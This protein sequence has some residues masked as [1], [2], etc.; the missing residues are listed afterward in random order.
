MEAEFPTLR[1]GSPERRCRL[2]LTWDGGLEAHLLY[3]WDLPTL[4]RGVFQH[5][6][7]DGV[8]GRILFESNGLYLH[9]RGPGRKGLSFPG[10]ADLMG[11]GRM[12]D[13]FLLCLS[14]REASPYSSLARARR[15]LDIV[16]RAYEHL[17]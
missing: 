14:S 11:Y 6:R 5:S 13:D 8:E 1:K 2:S 12:T 3:A 15:D 4:A 7:V 17:A 9:V 10:F 16:H